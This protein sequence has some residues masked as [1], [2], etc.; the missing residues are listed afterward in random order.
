MRQTTL[1]YVPPSVSSSWAATLGYVPAQK[2][3]DHQRRRNAGSEPADDV[4][5]GPAEIEIPRAK[6]SWHPVARQWYESLAQSAQIAYYQPSDWA[7]AFMVAESLSRDLKPRVVGTELLTSTDAEGNINQRLE[8]VRASMP[9]A[10]SSMNALTRAMGNL[11][12]THPDR[13]KANVKIAP[14]EDGEDG[15]VTWIDTARGRRTG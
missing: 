6:S 15:S 11:L 12:G 1:E 9:L 2:K 7:Y 4:I 13:T 3:P 10:G 8:V 5:T 14:V